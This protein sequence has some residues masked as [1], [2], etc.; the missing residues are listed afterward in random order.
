MGLKR[1][2]RPCTRASGNYDRALVTLRA[3]MDEAALVAA[4]AEGA[5][6]TLE[7]AVNLGLS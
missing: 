2:P 3:R 6:M 4:W 1:K 5:A 7:Q